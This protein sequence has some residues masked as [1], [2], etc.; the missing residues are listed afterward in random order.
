VGLSGAA[1]PTAQDSGGKEQFSGCAIFNPSMSG[2]L[3]ERPPL[4]KGHT[5]RVVITRL[6][7]FTGNGAA[8]LD[9]FTQGQW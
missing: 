3:S 7:S 8:C 6:K 4:L 1:D 2:R 5:S 9:L